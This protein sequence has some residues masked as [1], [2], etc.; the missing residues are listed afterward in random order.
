MW[1]KPVVGPFYFG[2][3]LPTTGRHGSRT[4]FFQVMALEILKTSSRP[5]EL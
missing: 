1:V 2:P 4:Y 3:M 5:Y